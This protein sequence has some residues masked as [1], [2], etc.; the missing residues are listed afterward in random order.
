[1]IGV[2]CSTFNFHY[3]YAKLG[4]MIGAS[5]TMTF[6]FTIITL[7][8]TTKKKKVVLQA[9]K[10]SQIT[11]YARKMSFYKHFASTKGASHFARSKSCK[12]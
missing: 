5:L 8:G 1:M 11:K 6:I 12:F 4:S 2:Y 3:Y 9:P 10:C 7:A